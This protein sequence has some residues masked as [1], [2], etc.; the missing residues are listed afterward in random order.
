MCIPSQDMTWYLWQPRFITCALLWNKNTFLP[1]KPV[2]ALF[3]TA[4]DLSSRFSCF[5]NHHQYTEWPCQKHHSF[6]SLEVTISHTYQKNRT[7][8]P[9]FPIN[10]SILLRESSTL[11]WNILVDKLTRPK[12]MWLLGIFGSFL[13]DLPVPQLS[14]SSNI[15]L[16]F[17]L[18]RVKI[19]SRNQPH[20]QTQH[21]IYLQS[22][23]GW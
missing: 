8:Q 22:S 18:F 6:W 11:Y 20:L 9:L 4:F 14:S 5:K 21:L 7:L 15:R 13:V 12:Q 16:A 3:H 19:P 17:V 10:L 1:R 23:Y 2:Y